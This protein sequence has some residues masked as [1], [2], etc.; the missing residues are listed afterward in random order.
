MNQENTEQRDASTAL[1][2][3]CD[4]SYEKIE[5][6]PTMWLYRKWGWLENKIDQWFAKRFKRFGEL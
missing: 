6:T 1:M 3:L 2:E 4:A 5:R